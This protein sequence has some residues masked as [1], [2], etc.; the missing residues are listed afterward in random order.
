MFYAGSAESESTASL[1]P[2][3]ESPSGSTASRS[4]TTDNRRTN[5]LS[6]GF[7]L[8]ERM[9]CEHSIDNRLDLR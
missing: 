2:D 1:L 5:V 4:P 9:L 7:P 3:G 6:V 8:E